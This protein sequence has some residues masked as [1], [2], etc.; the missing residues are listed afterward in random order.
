MMILLVITHAFRTNDDFSPE[1]L[2]LGAFI[3]D[4]SLIKYLFT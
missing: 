1:L 4:T 2:Y 3:F